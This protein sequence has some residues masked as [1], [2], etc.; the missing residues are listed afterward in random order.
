M[1]KGAQYQ[2][3]L[4]LISEIFKDARPAD[5]I[6][7]AYLRERK[8][9]GSKDRRFI[10]ETVWQIIRNRRRLEFDARSKDPRRILL[11]FLRHEDFDLLSADSPYALSPLSKEEK[12]WLS[13]SNDE[14][15]PSAVEAE[16]PDW[17]FAKINDMSLLKALNEPAAAD[18]RI[19]ALTRE[20]IIK[21]LQKEGLFFRPVRYSPI[22]IRSS[23]RVNLHNCMAYQEGEI[24]VQDEASQI[25]AILADVRPDHKAID[26]CC[27]AGGKALTIAFLNDNRGQL[28]IHDINWG[29]LEAVKDRAARLK[30]NN[31]NIVKELKD[32]DYNRFITDA[33]C[34]GSGTW[35]RS[36]DAKF[37]LTPQQLAELVK[38]QSAILETAYNHTAR[39]GRIVYFTCSIL[40]EENED[41]IVAFQKKHPDMRTVNLK[42]LWQQ[43]LNGIYPS[44]DEYHLHLNPLVS[45]TDGFFVCILEKA[46]ES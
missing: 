2:A 32:K 28:D 26:Y 38:T 44:A 6:I 8:Y 37:R 1:Q 41:V 29:R 7:N 24:E 25:A 17:L 22:G 16:T 40:R 35:R 14:P 30:I 10:T 33:P 13:V 15:Y 4:E 9:I 39:G 36:P 43:K 46:K 5:N 23:E 42:E 34:S 27:G 21:K 12:Q 19:N 20:L 11:Y 3:V 18:L 45:G 31:L